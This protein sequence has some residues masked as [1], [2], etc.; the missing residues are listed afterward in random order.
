MQNETKL[1]K[2]GQA[3]THH[4]EV[5]VGHSFEVIWKYTPTVLS[6][7]LDREIDAE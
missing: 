1:Y 3:W 4:L 2:I 6:N 7:S 5:Y